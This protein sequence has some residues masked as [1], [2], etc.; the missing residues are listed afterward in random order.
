MVDISNLHL[1]TSVV[2]RIE[3]EMY[4]GQLRAC[5]RALWVTKDFKI[6]L[7]RNKEPVQFS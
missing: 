1:T 7:K 6:N 2:D 4:I 5:A 3:L